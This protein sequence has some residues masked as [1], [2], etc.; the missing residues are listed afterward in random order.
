MAYYCQKI[1]INNFFPALL[2]LVSSGNIHVI[3]QAHKQDMYFSEDTSPHVQELMSVGELLNHPPPGRPGQTQLSLP[4]GD[5][6]RALGAAGQAQGSRT[7]AREQ[8]QAQAQGCGVGA[9][10]PSMAPAA[11]LGRPVARP[12]PWV[13][14]QAAL[15]DW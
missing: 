5:R 8:A 1:Y 3:F 4:R 7:R 14:A 2:I 6:R 13:H 11:A 9:A 10:G 15:P 12:C